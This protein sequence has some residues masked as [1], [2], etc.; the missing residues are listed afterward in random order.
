MSAALPTS[1]RVVGGAVAL[2]ALSTPWRGAQAWRP[3][4]STVNR[5]NLTTDEV[6]KRA[7]EQRLVASQLSAAMQLAGGD[8]LA[9]MLPWLEKEAPPRRTSSSR[10]LGE[11]WRNNVSKY[12]V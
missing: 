5:A 4:D 12:F 2:A 8:T 1:G 10:S 11:L 3:L 6:A 9:E 7:D